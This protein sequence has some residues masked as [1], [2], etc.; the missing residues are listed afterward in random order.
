M[1]PAWEQAFFWF[2]LE[3]LFK[4]LYASA[5]DRVATVKTVV[6]KSEEHP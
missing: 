5:R 2:L 4:A 1:K 6:K 3:Y